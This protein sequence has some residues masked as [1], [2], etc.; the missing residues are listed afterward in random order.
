MLTVLAFQASFSEKSQHEQ[1]GSIG[2]RLGMSHLFVLR[3]HGTLL[4]SKFFLS[5]PFYGQECRSYD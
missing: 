4:P 1:V 5:S 3:L 2:R